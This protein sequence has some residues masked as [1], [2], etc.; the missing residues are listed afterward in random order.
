M[1]K[2]ATAGIREC[3]LCQKL[4][5]KTY[6]QATAICGCCREVKKVD[7]AAAIKLEDFIILTEEIRNKNGRPRSLTPKD[8]ETIRAR[9]RRGTSMRKLSDEYGVSIGTIF[10]AVHS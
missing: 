4:N 2:T 8:K 6:K 5:G 10:N 3:Q 7:L 9:H 1:K